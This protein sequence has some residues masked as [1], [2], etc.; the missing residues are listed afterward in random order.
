MHSEYER[1]LVGVRRFVLEVR[2]RFTLESRGR[3]ILGEVYIRGGLQWRLTPSVC[4]KYVSEQ[5]LVKAEKP[6]LILTSEERGERWWWWWW[7]G[8]G[9]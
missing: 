6:I 5:T 3:F 4:L 7:L 2:G 1:P 8:G 9:E